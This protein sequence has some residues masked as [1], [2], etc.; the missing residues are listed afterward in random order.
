MNYVEHECE[1]V[2][3]EL[4]STE[5]VTMLTKRRAV[6]QWI[7]GFKEIPIHRRWLLLYFLQMS[8]SIKLAGCPSCLDLH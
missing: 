4:R 8:S 6:V 5:F 7:V 3:Q 2:E 1:L